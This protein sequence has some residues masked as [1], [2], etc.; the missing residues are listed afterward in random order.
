MNKEII[1]DLIYNASETEVANY[2][3]GCTDQED[4]YIYAFN[5]NWEGGFDIPK[6]IIN[7]PIC[8]ISTAKLIFWRADGLSYLRDKTSN[9]VFPEWKIFISVLYKRI[10]AN[11]FQTDNFQFIVPL[12]KV[13]KF[14]LKKKLSDEELPLIE[15]NEGMCLDVEL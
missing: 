4:L 14:K 10:Q 7:N 13:Q 9:D 1:A 12:S 5:Y 15:D 2:L 11:D 8:S 3:T 6:I